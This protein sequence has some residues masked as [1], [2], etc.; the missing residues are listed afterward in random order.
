MKHSTQA[1]AAKA[2]LLSLALVCLGSP[3]LAQTVQG[4]ARAGEKKNAMC[5]GCHG[6]PGYQASFPQVYKVPKISGQNARYLVAALDAYRKGERKHPSMNGVA[7]SLSDQD[8]A[9]LAAY[10]EAHGRT[11]KAPV[12]PAQA[13]LP[14]PLKDKLATCVACH[15]SNFN[16][17]TD[18]A[19]PR[20][21]GQH[22]DYLAVALRAYQAEGQHLVGRSN[23]TM[24]AMAKPLNA[25]EVRQIADYLASLPGELQTVPQGW[26]R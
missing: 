4:D 15:G 10:Y 16:N 17:T 25:A 19:N 8:I 6:I 20:L 9:D 13:E 14:A 3:A 21:A 23:A 2:T 26:T 7:G 11:G 5:I 12:V 1:M 22:A 18:P 24:V